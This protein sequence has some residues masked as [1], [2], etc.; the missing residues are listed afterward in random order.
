LALYHFNQSS[1]TVVT[2]DN[3]SGRT[4]DNGTLTG[5]TLPTWT[6]GGL[7][8]NGLTLGYNTQNG[9]D[10][11]LTQPLDY[12][13]EMQFNWQFTYADPVGTIIDCTGGDFLRTF[14]YDNGSNPALTPMGLDFV[15]RDGSAVYHDITTPESMALFAGQYYDIALTRSWDGAT[16]VWSLYVNGALANSFS[17]GGFWSSSSDVYIG[18]NGGGDQS[19]RG[20]V[21]EFRFSDAALTQF[22]DVV[23][24]PTT[25]ALLGLGGLLLLPMLRRHRAG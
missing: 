6:T 9:V 15:V 8:G 2:D 18:A 11:G 7:F 14:L 12:T 13:M 24:E 5:S 20:T 21:D 19:V 22:G 1:G 4:A 17:S 3:S 16:A 23:P 25:V 10:T